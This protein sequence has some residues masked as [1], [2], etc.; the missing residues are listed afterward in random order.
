MRDITY[1]Q[2]FVFI[3]R[4][5]VE[6]CNEKKSGNVM[7]EVSVCQVFSIEGG[8]YKAQQKRKLELQ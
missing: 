7:L 3:G 6:E 8:E 4:I 1:R 2:G 5:G